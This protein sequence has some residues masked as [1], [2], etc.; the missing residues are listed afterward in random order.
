MPPTS[1]DPWIVEHGGAV[2]GLVMRGAALVTT[3]AVK[4]GR[5]LAS[6][7]RSV[8]L[9][10]EDALL[11]ETGLGF[12]A[13]RFP[14]LVVP[15]FM[16]ALLLLLH[17]ARGADSR[18]APLLR[19][20]PAA[21]ELQHLPIFMSSKRQAT[22]K[23]TDAAALLDELQQELQQTYRDYVRPIAR[24]KGSPFGGAVPS[25]ERWRWSLAMVWRCA[26]P[27]GEAKVIA[28]LLCATAHGPAGGD[29]WAEYVDHEPG[30]AAAWA[31]E[32]E[33]MRARW[34]KAGDGLKLVATRG[35]EAGEAVRLDFGA[36]SNGELL[37]AR[38]EALERN[39]RDNVRFHIE[40]AA[41]AL[42]LSLT[43]THP[44]TSPSPDHW[45]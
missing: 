42:S 16:L 12:V 45:P 41:A 34:S 44:P 17:D 4:K 10:S 13:E 5:Q 38:G 7:P 33:S 11:P 37:V 9:S 39:A 43:H 36:R 25:L 2:D 29:A 14:D 20:L 32:A 22:L 27:H 21:D 40:V 8:L 6:L 24:A 15:P 28:P 18:L 23:G 35:L 19:S 26:V 3:A 31:A 1:C 30:R